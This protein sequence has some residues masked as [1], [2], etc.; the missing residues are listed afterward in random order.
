[1]GDDDK[2]RQCAAQAERLAPDAPI[3][4]SAKPRVGN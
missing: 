1:L 2:A 3:T 4:P